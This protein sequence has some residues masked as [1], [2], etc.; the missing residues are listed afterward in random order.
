LVDNKYQFINNIQ[1]VIELRK[2]VHKFY[3][4]EFTNGNFQEAKNKLEN[5]LKGDRKRA[6]AMI[7]FYIGMAVT[8]LLIHLLLFLFDESNTF[9]K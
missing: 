3:A 4:E 5:R 1:D 6:T 7:Y 9:I 2:N 8:L